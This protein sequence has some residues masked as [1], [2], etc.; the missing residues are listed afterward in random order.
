MR[1]RPRDAGVDERVLREA[2]LMLLA[3]GY[4]GLSCEAVAERAGVAKTTLYRRWPTKD[5]LAVAVVARLQDGDLIGETG[6]IRRD[7][8]DYME[9]IA[10]GLNRMRLAG[11]TDDDPWYPGA[12][13]EL[14]GASGRHRDIARLR[15]QVYARRNELAV[16]LIERAVARGDLPAG[17]DAHTLLE[18]LAGALYY[19]VLITGDPVDRSYAEKLV[20]SALAHII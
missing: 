17:L 15:R 4:G 5:H 16:G 1:G 18:Q 20:A 3:E 11:R 10:A 13:A 2:A 6:D 9:Q 12:A 19:R 14:V 7:L 8:T